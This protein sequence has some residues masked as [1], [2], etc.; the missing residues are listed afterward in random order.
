MSPK[1]PKSP[2]VVI[3]TP[4]STPTQSLWPSCLPWFQL[5]QRLSYGELV[6]HDTCRR[7]ELTKYSLGLFQTLGRFWQFTSEGRERDG[8]HIF[9][10]NITFPIQ[11]ERV[12]FM[13]HR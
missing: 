7:F 3:F 5:Q 8:K 12:R 10:L 1:T 9:A 13:F 6:D 4:A 2:K 11:L